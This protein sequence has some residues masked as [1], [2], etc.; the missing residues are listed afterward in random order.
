MLQGHN[1]LLPSFCAN[2]LC[3]FFLSSLRSDLSVWKVQLQ[4]A[5]LIFSSLQSEQTWNLA[6]NWVQSVAPEIMSRLH[7]VSTSEMD[8][9]VMKTTLD[10]WVTFLAD[11]LK[12][13]FGGSVWAELR[14]ALEN[15]FAGCSRGMV[16]GGFFNKNI[17]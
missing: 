8:T 17:Q 6:L 13:V 7:L 11:C 9:Q 5:T 3:F 2:A 16:T 1:R 4:T 12:Q 14:T 15:T 10:H